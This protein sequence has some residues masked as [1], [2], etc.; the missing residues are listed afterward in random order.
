MIPIL[1]SVVLDSTDLSNLFL[2]VLEVIGKI[3]RITVW[4]V[5]VAFKCKTCIKENIRITQIIIW[6]DLS[7]VRDWMKLGGEK[8]WERGVWGGK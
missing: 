3:I 1:T 7:K 8:S 6:K 2:K 4:K 5:I